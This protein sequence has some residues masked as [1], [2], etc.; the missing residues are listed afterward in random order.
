MAQTERC[1]RPDLHNRWFDGDATNVTFVTHD[2]TA[3]PIPD[4]EFDVIHA[5][6]VLEHLGDPPA[7]IARLVSAL[8]PGGVLLVQDASGLEL[9]T[10]PPRELLSRLT[11]VWE[12]AARA[13]G[14]EPCYGTR[15]PGDLL[16]AGLTDVRG[17]EHRLV[18]PGGPAWRHVRDGLLRLRDELRAE[19]FGG[20][21]LDSVP[22]LI[23]DRDQLITGP[24]ITI[25]W[26]RRA[27]G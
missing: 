12:R 8:R 6:L 11:R 1:W 25:A 16:A 14:W 5:R 15:L 21:D 23:S 20:S 10:T 13:V 9:I 4:R 18:A 26:G 19:R 17:R 24:P 3:D 22:R 2:V 7:A 27:G